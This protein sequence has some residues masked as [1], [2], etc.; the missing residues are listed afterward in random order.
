MAQVISRYE[1]E[2]NRAYSKH[3]QGVS[4]LVSDGLKAL[5]AAFNEETNQCP[6]GGKCQASYRVLNAE[7]TSYPSHMFDLVTIM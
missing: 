6:Y 2:L 4:M 5:Q 1:V 3:V 7:N